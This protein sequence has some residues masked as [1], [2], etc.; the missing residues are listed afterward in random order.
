M[1]TFEFVASERQYS[2]HLLP[3]WTALPVGARGRWVVSRRVAAWL[4]QRG[5]E[6]AVVGRPLR[7]GGPVV[8]ASWRDLHNASPREAVMVQHGAGQTYCL[9]PYTRVMTDDLRWVPIGDI[10]AGDGLAAFEENPTDRRWRGWMWT[11]ATA[12]RRLHLP[13]RRLE[14]ADGTVV[15]AS[16]DHRW[17]KRNC[18]TYEWATTKDLRARDVWG[19]DHSSKVVK[20]FDPWEEDRSWGAGYLAAAFD[21]EGSLTQTSRPG[22]Q[23]RIMLTFVQKDNAMLAD[24]ESELRQRGFTFSVNPQREDGVRY[25]NVTGGTKEILRF[26]G[27]IRPRRLLAKFVPLTKGQMR[28]VDVELLSNEPIGDHEVVAVTTGTGTLFA[29]GFASHNSGDP[30]SAGHPSYTGGGQRDNVVLNVTGGPRDA[31]RLARAQP[32]VPAVAVGCPKLDRWHGDDALIRYYVGRGSR[33]TVAISWHAEVAL[34]PE[35]R[36]AW[37]HYGPAALTALQA[38][39]RFRLVGHAHPR[40]W[41]RMRRVYDELGIESVEHFDAVLERADIYLVDNSSTAWE[42]ASLGRPVIS[43]NAPWYRRDVDHGLRFW[44]LVPGRQVDGPEGLADAIAAEL[45][46]PDDYAGL[47]RRAVDAVYSRCDGHASDRAAQAIVEHWT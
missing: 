3:I 24:V 36:S 11:T 37:P 44:D 10:V 9:A 47:R 16:E 30:K 42:F 28:G 20:A 1:P 13:S 45:A 40:R 32:D 8:V 4:A 19:S 39:D 17:L 46:C 7:T 22:R 29:E 34:C 5:V 23:N 27:S 2:E 12:V 25:I 14:F 38:D 33:P 35:S 15:I 21:G 18:G 31:G 43:L 6:A 26:V 41:D